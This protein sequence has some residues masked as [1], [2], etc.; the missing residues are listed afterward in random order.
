MRLPGLNVFGPDVDWSFAGK[1]KEVFNGSTFITADVVSPATIDLS[2]SI[3]P[4]GQCGLQS[5]DPLAFLNG[6]ESI[7]L[8]HKGIILS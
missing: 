7:L 2:R 4:Q 8:I 6:N 1:G 5:S 3:H